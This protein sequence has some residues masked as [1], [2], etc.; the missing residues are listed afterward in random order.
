MIKSEVIDNRSRSQN[1]TRSLAYLVVAGAEVGVA[2]Q[3]LNQELEFDGIS[4]FVVQCGLARLKLT[5][6]V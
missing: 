3:E 2:S 1:R 6:N 5:L 4:V